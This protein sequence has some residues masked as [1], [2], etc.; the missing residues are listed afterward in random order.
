M[1][2]S[3]RDSVDQTA[4]DDLDALLNLA[5]P[6]AT[7]CLTKD[8][9]FYPFAA[10]ID[11]D[12]RQIHIATEAALSGNA[13]PSG[14]VVAECYEALAAQRDALR[15]A[16]VVSDVRL[17]GLGGDAVHFALEHSVGFALSLVQPY[18]LG[19]AGDVELGSM[20]LVAGDRVT[21]PETA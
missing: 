21:W 12:G 3:W 17:S 18:T 14:V 1:A 8:G 19:Q 16:V 13:V 9:E 5:L 6:F 7:Q 10:G 2:S 4:Q 15:A 20:S 11:D